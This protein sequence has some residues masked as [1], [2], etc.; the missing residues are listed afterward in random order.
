MPASHP[1]ARTL[2]AQLLSFVAVGVV[3]AVVDFGVLVALMNGAG[4][5]HTPAKGLSWVA[6]T[7]T[8]YLLNARWTFDGG[9]SRRKATAVA[10][11]YACTFAVQVGLFSWIFPPLAT[12]AGATPAQVGAFVIAQGVAT[13]TNFVVQRAVIFRA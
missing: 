8:A 12:A 9:G 4:W 2:R 10:A 1:P 5:D 13:L 11:L 6:G 7:T 3:S